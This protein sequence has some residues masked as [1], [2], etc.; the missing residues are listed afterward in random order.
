MATLLKF[1]RRAL[2]K[3]AQSALGLPGDRSTR[4]LMLLAARA[5]FKWR[6]KEDQHALLKEAKK[7]FRLLTKLPD[8]L[9]EHVRHGD[10]C[11]RPRRREDRTRRVA[12]LQSVVST[13]DNDEFEE[14]VE[15]VVDCL[16]ALNG[17]DAKTEAPSNPGFKLDHCLKHIETFAQTGRLPQN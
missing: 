2:R 11:S 16:L 13:H 5:R 1:T 12:W 6:F 9:E 8:T 15:I 17:Y 3:R 10:L 4:A 7:R 14:A